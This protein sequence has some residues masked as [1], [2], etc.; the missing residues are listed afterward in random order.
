MT[1]IISSQNAMRLM[2]REFVEAIL[3]LRPGDVRIRNDMAPV[4]I[5]ALTNTVNGSY[6]YQAADVS[7]SSLEL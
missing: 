3:S 7:W 2:M 4:Q 5:Q 1:G 6:R